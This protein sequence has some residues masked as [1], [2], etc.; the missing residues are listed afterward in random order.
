MLHFAWQNLAS[1]PA[2]SILALLGLTVAIT[3]MV[4]LFSIAVGLQRTVGRTF[5]RIPGLAAMQPG[6][7]IPLFSRMPAAWAEEIREVPGV[8]VVRPEL[9][10]R[11]QMV[12]GKMTFNPPRF[13]FG[14]DIPTTL[15]MKSAVYR[16]DIQAGRF[17]EL[18][19]VGT[20]RCVISEAIA[21]D[22]NKKPGDI[23]KVD[24]NLLEVIGV[25]KTGSILLDVAIVIDQSTLRQLYRMDPSIISSVYIEPVDKMSPDELSKAIR[26]KFRGRSLGKWQPS[27]DTIAGLSGRSE[28]TLTDKFVA[29]LSGLSDLAKPRKPSSANSSTS[30]EVLLA[31]GEKPSPEDISGENSAADPGDAEEGL[32]V[33]SA[34]DWGT[35]I[36]EFS[37]DLDIFMYLM[38]GIGVVIALLSILNTMLMS[39]TERMTEFGILKANGWSSWD[40]LRLIAYESAALGLIGGILGCTLGWI[41]TLV[42]NASI[43]DKL[44]LYASPGLLLFSLAFSMALGVLGGLYPALWAT[45]LTPMEAI[46]RS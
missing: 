14:T 3:G 20:N 40:L 22:S 42:V 32:E 7:P 41:G 4:G 1:R 16:D 15:Q 26:E 11:A 21:R 38:S 30:G 28:A 12:D 39:V 17:L 6:A 19:D 34:R 13:L 35:K 33:R 2:R 10:T 43:P 31:G 36:Q 46:R 44:N 27:A 45:R 37:S 24:G 9:W 18:A 5:D 25:Y 23:I 8:S 29:G